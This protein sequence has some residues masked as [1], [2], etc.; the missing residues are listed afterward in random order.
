M[1]KSH[2]S[3]ARREVFRASAPIPKCATAQ[4]L[5]L[6]C[7]YLPVIDSLRLWIPPYTLKPNK[8]NRFFQ[9]PLSLLPLFSRL[10]ASPKDLP[11]NSQRSPR[12]RVQRQSTL[13]LA[14]RRPRLA[15]ILHRRTS[16]VRVQPHRTLP[17]LLLASGNAKDL[18]PSPTRLV[19]MSTQ[20]PPVRKTLLRVY[21]CT[22][23]LLA[24]LRTLRRLYP[25]PTRK[26][27]V[28]IPQLLLFSARQ[29]LR[30]RG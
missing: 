11:Q 27:C 25:S 7:T 26:L 13:V 2:S 28:P 21:F 23:T 12:V 29:S 10:L 14:Q 5:F 4:F 30:D 1:A 20:S 15:K 17:P 8:A 18:S 9:L 22:R 3:S 6:L 19:A 16:H 24:Q